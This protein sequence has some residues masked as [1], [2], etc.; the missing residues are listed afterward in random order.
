MNKFKKALD[1]YKR[2]PSDW[3]RMTVL[4]M[5]FSLLKRG[6]V[7]HLPLTTVTP[8]PTTYRRVSGKWVAR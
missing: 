2:N 1:E 5:S 8:K 3:N 6:C 4:L 7:A